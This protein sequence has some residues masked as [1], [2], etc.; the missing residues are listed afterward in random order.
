MEDAVRLAEYCHV[1]AVQ[2]EDEPLQAESL[3]QLY[4]LIQ[5]RER[6]QKI[7]DLMIIHYFNTRYAISREKMLSCY[8]DLKFVEHQYH[9]DELTSLFEDCLSAEY[10]HGHV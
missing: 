7:E 2:A 10:W 5:D 6:K 1:L 8:Q 3:I 4:Q 9:H